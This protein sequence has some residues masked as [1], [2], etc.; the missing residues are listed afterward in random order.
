MNAVNNEAIQ[1]VIEATLK[2]LRALPDGSHCWVN[3]RVYIPT[4]VLADDLAKAGCLQVDS[5]TE[6]QIDDLLDRPH[7]PDGSGHNP[8]Y[9]GYDYGPEAVRAALRRC[10]TGEAE[11]SERSADP[12]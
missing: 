11:P 6:R 8:E 9:D 1:A 10:A 7:L 5:L 2:R 3:P 4:D 12:E